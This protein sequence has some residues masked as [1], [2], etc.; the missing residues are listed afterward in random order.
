VGRFRIRRKSKALT[1]VALF[2]FRSS[3]NSSWRH[4]DRRWSQVGERFPLLPGSPFPLFSSVSLA[5]LDR[6]FQIDRGQERRG[7]EG[8]RWWRRPPF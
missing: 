5:L 8:G 2:G 4:S 6:P 1:P 3:P 7:D